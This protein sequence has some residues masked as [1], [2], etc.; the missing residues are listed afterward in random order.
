M[1]FLDV[2]KGR[3]SIR[4]Y[5]PKE[6]EK[7]KIDAILEAAQWAPSASNKQPWHFIVVRDS[8]T[9][10]RLG[11]LHPYGRF[12]KQSPVVIVVLGNPEMHPKYYLCDPHQAVQNILL[13]AYSLGLGSCW[14][15]VRGASFENDIKEMLGIPKSLTVV[16]TISIGYPNHKRKST[17]Y[18]LGELVSWEQFGTSE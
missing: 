17:R 13:T 10:T 15:G 16:C 2:I 7:E 1:E 9:R 4:Q 14:M 3:R 6:V 11:Q 18:P 5:L 12:M 8:D